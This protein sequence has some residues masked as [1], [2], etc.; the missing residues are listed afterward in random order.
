M[1]SAAVQFPE[2]LVSFT[3]EATSHRASSR[4][5]RVSIEYIMRAEFHIDFGDVFGFCSDLS[6]ALN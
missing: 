6:T 2:A 1:P 3:D 5:N 4:L